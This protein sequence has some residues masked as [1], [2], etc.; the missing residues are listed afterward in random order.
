MKILKTFVSLFS[1]LAF[2]D[3]QYFFKRHPNQPLFVPMVA[4]VGTERTMEEVHSIPLGL[5]HRLG[6]NYPR[7]KK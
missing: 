2:N 7:V 1:R 6:K 4:V 5:V 3:T